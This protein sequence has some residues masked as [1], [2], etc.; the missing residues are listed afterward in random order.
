MLARIQLYAPDVVKK[1][2][3]LGKAY[4]LRYLARKAIRTPTD[5]T[6]AK[7]LINRSLNTYWQ[8]LLEEPIV[9]IKIIGAAY[10]LP[11][12]PK[13]FAQRI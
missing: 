11:L 9:T 3:N 2:E 4:Q 12:F 13:L 6:L 8:I 7:E 10:L 5:K 1:W